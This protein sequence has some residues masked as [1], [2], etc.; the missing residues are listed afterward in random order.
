[1]RVLESGGTGSGG[2]TRDRGRRAC[3]GRA[4]WAFSR[5]SG[6]QLSYFAGG[7]NA[8]A[9]RHQM[10]VLGTM[11][12]QFGRRYVMCGGA[13]PLVSHMPARSGNTAPSFAIHRS[14]EQLRIKFLD[15]LVL[16]HSRFW[17]CNYSTLRQC[18]INRLANMWH[19]LL[20]CIN[21]L[22]PDP[23]T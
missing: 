8:Q 1:M 13:A 17:I 15:K 16:F 22:I 5:L 10:H 14:C 9:S 23:C 21:N 20:Q 18:R 12:L 19:I 7:G 3:G 11:M 4:I 2:G 6:L